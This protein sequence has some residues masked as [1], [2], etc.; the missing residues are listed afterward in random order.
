M[1]AM[2]VLCKVDMYIGLDDL[3]THPLWNITNVFK[4]YDFL[5]ILLICIVK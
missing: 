3:R 4:L 1:G 2:D 5:Y